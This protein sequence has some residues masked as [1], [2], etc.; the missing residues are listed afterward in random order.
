MPPSSKFAGVDFSELPIEHLTS[1]LTISGQGFRCLRG[2]FVTYWRQGRIQR[3]I[4]ARISQCWILRCEDSLA[5][6]ITLLTDK[7]ELDEPILLDEGVQYRSFPAIKI[8]LLAV[9]RRAKGAGRRLVEWAV[10]YVAAEISPTV[11]VRF[12]TVDALYD[13]DTT[14]PYDAS[15]F[16]EKFGFQFV[17]PNESLPSSVPYRTMYLDLKPLIDL[18]SIEDND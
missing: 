6:Y 1:E 16:Y 7:L 11:G 14:P 9:D 8:G 4:D 13:P 12:M 3:D 2:E 5:G 17:D 15:G 10:E 18:L